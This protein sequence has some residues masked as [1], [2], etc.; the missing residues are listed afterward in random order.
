MLKEIRYAIRSLLKQPGFTVVAI[1]TLTL[2]IGANS[3]IFSVVNGVLL[4]PLQYDNPDGIVTILQHGQGPVAPADFLD[5]KSQSKSFATMA[6][7]QAWSG[8]L[9]GSDR[10]ESILGIRYTEGMF[11]V[12]GVK[13]LWGRTFQADDFKPGNDHVLVLDHNLWQRRFGGDPKII[14]Q[15]V[16]FNGLQYTVIGVMPPEFHFTPFW[17]TKSE[18]AAPL[19][20]SSQTTQ[21]DGNSLRVFARM[22]PGTSLGQAQT[23]MNTICERLAQAYPETNTGRTVQVDPLIEKVVGNIRQALLVLTFSVLFVLLI[24]CVNVANLQLVRSAARQKEMALRVALGA[25]RWRVIRQLLTESALLTATSAIAGVL[26]GFWSLLWIKGLLA[27]DS[28][29]FRVRMPRISE[30]SI[31]S[32]TLLFTLTVAVITGLIFGIVPAFQAFRLD[33]QTL[34]DS[35]R[36]SS[37]SKRSQKLRHVL[38][39]S[40]VALAVITMVGAGLMLRSF[41]RLSAIDPGFN[42]QNVLS[43]VVSLRGQA[44]MVGDKREAFYR[45]LLSELKVLP[46]V[47]SVSAINHLPLAGDIWNRSVLVEGR[48]LPKPEEDTSAVWRVCSPD[49]FKT[50]GIKLVT[51]RD[52][53]DQDRNDSSGVIIINERLAQRYWPNESPIARRVTFDD[54]TKNPKWMSIVGVVQDVRQGDWT[55]KPSPEFYIPFSQSSFR[56]QF[57]DMTLVIRTEVEPTSVIGSVQNTVWKVNKEVPVSSIFTVEQAIANA[58]WQPRFNVVLIAL[59]AGLALL[60]GAVGI[61]GVMAY[62]VTQRTQEIGIRMAL[63]ACKSDV[64]RLIVGKGMTLVLVGTTIGLAGAFALTRFMNT[65]LFGVETTDALSF[66][67]ATLGLVL[68]A[69]LACYLPAR[70]ATKVDPLVALRYQ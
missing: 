26:L 50:M 43:M 44:D 18:L 13:P 52:F 70:R 31:D 39:V 51:G 10:P 16:N 12:L 67:I 19:D 41:M 37:G 66:G 47:T 20:L 63:G 1:I 9:T 5:W 61:Y 2:G 21:R 7:A 46:G 36:G 42:P 54:P 22:K 53:N 35:G 59:F 3:A 23:E 17:A 33:P 40:E 69:L 11:E 4:K 65:L 8:T 29:S 25:S 30:I 55:Q 58:V 62:A 38:V 68:V 28:S 56:T 45:E 57:S 49:Y 14:G 27:G 64:L 32:S 15:A 6:A 34:K 24:A 60:L 48:P